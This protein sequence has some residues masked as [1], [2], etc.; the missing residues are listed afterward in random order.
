MMINVFTIL[1]LNFALAAE[2]YPH[3]TT[4]P[5]TLASGSVSFQNTPGANV[6]S[7]AF[8]S[9]LSI[10]IT[11]DFEIGTI[12]LLYFQDNH[13]YNFNLKYSLYKNE[14]SSI[15]LG[16][17]RMAFKTDE[18]QTQ[19]RFIINLVSLISYVNISKNITLG[20]TFTRNSSYV[21]KNIAKSYLTGDEFSLD[22]AYKIHE[23][24]IISTGV[25]YHQMELGVSGTRTIF[26]F[27][28]S[29]T[30]LRPQKTFSSPSFGLHYLP[31]KKE[32]LYLLSTSFY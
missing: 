19:D 23:N 8:M 16:Y 1:Y 28:S 21:E 24:Y 3:A 13:Q 27:G 5:D 26:G 25:G 9:S 29:I 20:L 10:G 17:T 4:N 18:K 15:S 31:E 11:R 7:S 32:F 14:F 6:T 30:I 2:Y 22:L 12:P